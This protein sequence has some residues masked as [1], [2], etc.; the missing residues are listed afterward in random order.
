MVTKHIFHTSTPPLIKI[1]NLLPSFTVFQ[2]FIY[3]VKK[4][5]FLFYMYVNVIY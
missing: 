3:A 5:I 4:I 2:R 1:I